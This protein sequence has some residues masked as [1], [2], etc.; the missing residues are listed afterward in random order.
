MGLVLMAEK[1]VLMTVTTV[2]QRVSVA[3]GMTGNDGGQR[4]PITLSLTVMK[5]A[6]VDNGRV[7][8]GE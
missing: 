1:G 4:R 3:A 2:G 5:V 8:V 6:T 7:N